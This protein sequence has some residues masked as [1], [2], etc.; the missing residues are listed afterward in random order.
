MFVSVFE[1]AD[2]KLDEIT[3]NDPR[4]QRCKY[5]I[6]T[7]LNVGQTAIDRFVRELEKHGMEAIKE[8]LCRRNV[9]SERK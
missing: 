2:A 9:D 3:S 1:T 4:K 6:K 5:F 8:I 7:M